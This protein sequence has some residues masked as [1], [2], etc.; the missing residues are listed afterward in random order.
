MLVSLLSLPAWAAESADQNGVVHP[1]RGEL[2]KA[3]VIDFA[4]VWCGPCWQALPRLEA[5]AQRYP[6]V[7]FLVISVDRERAG[8]DRLVEELGLT[9][10]VLWD[11]GHSIAEHYRPAGM[12]AT[13]VVGTDGETLHR[14]VGSHES[15]WAELTR[16][17]GEIA[18]AKP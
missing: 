14:H 4:A 12:P 1:W 13:F 17:L 3:T 16:V 10:P 15:G 8:R 18:A 7:Q 6:S 5:L 11:D 2:P 9:L